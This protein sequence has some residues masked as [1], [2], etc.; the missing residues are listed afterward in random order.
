MARRVIELQVNVK[1]LAEL[2]KGLIEMG[3]DVGM[4][5]LT[6]ATA[7]GAR[8]VRD[9]ARSLVPVD[10]GNL[11]RNIVISKYKRVKDKDREA[12][13]AVVIRTKGKAGAKDN[14]FY[15]VFV[16]RG[17][18]KMAARPFMRPAWES[19]RQAAADT[20]ISSIEKTIVDE[21]AKKG[22]K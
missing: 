2:E 20:V 22:F 8:I 11:K 12:R 6:G 16:E 15:G 5:G 10:T 3:R 18:S 17:T 13:Y 7:D 19:K 14:A 21:K 9:K 4:K 1:G